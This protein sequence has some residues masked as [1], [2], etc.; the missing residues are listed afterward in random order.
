MLY[1]LELCCVFN[2]MHGNQIQMIALITFL[3][4]ESTVQEYIYNVK[5]PYIDDNFKKQ[6]PTIKT[7]QHI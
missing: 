2:R 1:H 7:S 3:N 5:I 6:H 4:D